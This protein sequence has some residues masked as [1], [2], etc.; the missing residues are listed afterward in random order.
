MTA[1]ETAFESDPQS[2]IGAAVK[3][4]GG[5]FNGL[6]GNIVL[7]CDNF[8]GIRIEFENQKHDVVEAIHFLS[9]L[10]EHD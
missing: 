9:P 2:V 6:K 1:I 8:C 3:F 7:A 5:K 10:S 4:T